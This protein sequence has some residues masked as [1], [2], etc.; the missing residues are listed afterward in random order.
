MQRLRRFCV[1]AEIF[2]DVEAAVPAPILPHQNFQKDVICLLCVCVN[3]APLPCAA[4]GM[5]LEANL[6]VALARSILL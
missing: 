4:P 1:L 6:F 5:I 3:A 2:F